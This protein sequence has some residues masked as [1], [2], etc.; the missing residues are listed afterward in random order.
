MTCVFGYS[1]VGSG[2]VAGDGV[3]NDQFGWSVALSDDGTIMVVGAPTDDDGAGTD[4]GAVYTYDLVLGSW[5][6][7][8]SVLTVPSIANFA[9]YGSGVAL[10]GDGNVLVVGAYG[11]NASFGRVRTYDRSGST[12]VLRGSALSAGDGVSNDR[13]GTS[14]ALSSDGLIMAVGAQLRGGVGGVYIYDWVTSAWVQRGSV[15]TGAT[16]NDAFGASVALSDSGD[17]LVVGA[18]GAGV[19]DTGAVYTYDR[20]GS[21]WVQRG[22][23]LEVAGVEAWYGFGRSVS[24]SGDG[25]LLVVGAWHPDLTDLYPG[26][27]RRFNLSG[28]S[29]IEP[30]GIIYPSPDVV[31]DY[32]EIGC[33]VALSSDGTVLVAGVCGKPDGYYNGAVYQFSYELCV[34]L[35]SEASVSDSGFDIER[36]IVM[37]L[38]SNATATGIFSTVNQLT[39]AIISAVNATDTFDLSDSQLGLDIRSVVRVLTDGMVIDGGE[40]SVWV[41]NPRT[42]ASW[43]YENYGFSQFLKTERFTYGVKSDGIYLLDG[44]DDAGEPIRASLDVGRQNFG[45][46][47]NK[48]LHTAYVTTDATGGLQLRVTD[49]SGNAY[50]YRLTP[51]ERMDTVRAQLG[52]GL[53][54]NFFDVQLFNTEGGDFDLASIEL[55]Y[56]VLTRR[57]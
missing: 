2:L 5:V 41:I 15:L 37:V 11:D 3:A 35:V 36:N 4:N 44:D 25:S 30:A 27:V 18:T 1:Q 29:W 6:Q 42:G 47:K 57:V 56:D 32:D 52:R 8:G 23:A 34:Q 16:L 14:V 40:A 38:V 24:L 55:L 45:T 54:A 13:F 46:T 9:Y 22:V 17:V 10:S 51:N 50:M 43:R 20:S 33:G 39:L 7:R 31:G 12:W 21:A 28:S 26:E 48:R 19:T 53:V 49:D